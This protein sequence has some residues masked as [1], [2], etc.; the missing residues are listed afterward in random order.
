MSYGRPTEYLWVLLLPDTYRKPKG[1]LTTRV[2]QKTFRFLFRIPSGS[3]T[4]IVLQNNFGSSYYRSYSEYLQ[5]LL[6]P[7][8][9]RILSGSLLLP[10]LFRIHSGSLTTRVLH[11]C[12]TFRF[13]YYRIP[14]KYFQVLLLPESYKIP[15]FSITTREYRILSG[16]LTTRVLQKKFRF[17]YYYSPTEY[18]RFSYYYSPTEYFRVLLLP[19]SYR[20]PSGSL[21][22]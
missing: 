17:S 8:S 15:S 4:T 5:V 16:Y 13:S 19:E 1:S 9:Y 7:E 11:T 21:T 6:L 18:F 3:P 14:T 2:L 22:T 10:E 20:I 12:N